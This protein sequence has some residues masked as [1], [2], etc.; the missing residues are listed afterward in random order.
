MENDQL[1]VEEEEAETRHI[2]SE[3]IHVKV[4]ECVKDYY[5]F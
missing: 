1:S 2:A 4:L 5:S 3:H